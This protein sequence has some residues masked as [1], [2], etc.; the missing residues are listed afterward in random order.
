MP[1]SCS[2]QCA[3][4]SAVQSAVQRA[5]LMVDQVS[6]QEINSQHAT[7]FADVPPLVFARAAVLR[8]AYK[9]AEEAMQG[10]YDL[11]RRKGFKGVTLGSG[12]GI[13]LAYDNSLSKDEDLNKLRS[14]FLGPNE[15]K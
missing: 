7:L 12:R 10:T 8:G 14:M 6:P 2:V 1:V 13:M 3:V 5:V 9:T 11:H 4:Q 15:G